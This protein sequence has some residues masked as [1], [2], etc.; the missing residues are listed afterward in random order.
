MPS[1][2]GQELAGVYEALRTYFE[3]RRNRYVQAGAAPVYEPDSLLTKAQIPEL[4]KRTYEMYA[5]ILD[6]KD[7]RE[8]ERT[9]ETANLLL[10]MARDHINAGKD[11]IDRCVEQANYMGRALAEGDGEKLLD[12]FLL[13]NIRKASI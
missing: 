3:A 11:R 8:M 10:G 13:A 12:G 9:Y 7:R 4:V 6:N 1:E 5:D 2:K